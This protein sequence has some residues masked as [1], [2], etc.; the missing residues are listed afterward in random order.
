[1]LVSLFLALNFSLRFDLVNFASKQNEGE[2]FLLQKAKFYIFC[3]ISLPNFISGEKHFYQFFRLI[4]VSLRFFR[5]I[6]LILP[7]F[8]LQIFG[9]L[10]RSESCEIRLFSLPSETKFSLQFQIWLPKRK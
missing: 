1:M 2:N 8:S 4:F 9:V 5:L 10:H 3:I 6:S 7:S